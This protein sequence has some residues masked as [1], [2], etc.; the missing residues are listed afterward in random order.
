MYR[1]FIIDTLPSIPHNNITNDEYI[2]KEINF[3]IIMVYDNYIHL[4]KLLDCTQPQADKKYRSEE[5]F[6]IR[7]HHI[8]EINFAQ[9]LTD[10]NDFDLLIENTTTDKKLSSLKRILS[11]WELNINTLKLLRHLNKEDFLG[12]RPALTGISGM[13]SSQYI[14]W[15]NTYYKKRDRYSSSLIQYPK[16]LNMLQAIHIAHETWLSAHEEVILHFIQNDFGT[17]DTEGLRYMQD[18]RD[19]YNTLW[20]D[21][22]GILKKTV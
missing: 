19:L 12:F 2:L 21:I 3:L 13:Q 7:I 20:N 9:I 1:V 4:Q 6:F 11:C 17:G 10:I 5:S 15:I 18:Q 16:I 8:H 22:L 14:I